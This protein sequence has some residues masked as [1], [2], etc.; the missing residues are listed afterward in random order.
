[1][2]RPGLVD[3]GVQLTFQATLIHRFQRDQFDLRS[4]TGG[5]EGFIAGDADI[6]HGGD[7]GAEEFTRV[8]FAR[9]GGHQATH[10]TGGRQ[11][12]VG[13]DVDLAHAVLDAFDDFFNRRAVGFFDVA[14]V[15]VD[16]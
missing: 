4:I 3:L 10:R 1:V 13:V 14:D 7:S 6:T 8:E 2:S 11:A 12:Q 5:A 15:L 9:V 16:D